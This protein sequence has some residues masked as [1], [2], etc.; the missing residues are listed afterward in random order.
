VT[1]AQLATAPFIRRVLDDG[2]IVSLRVSPKASS[3]AIDG[4]HLAADGSLAL[5]VRVTAPADKGM[6][7]KAVIAL[8]AKA[9]GQARSS[10]EIITGHTSRDKQIRITGDPADIAGFLTQA[11]GPVQST[12]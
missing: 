3:S 7:N 5:K 10:F 1:A 4:Y 6:A 9:L 11:A 2:V 12:E 8:L